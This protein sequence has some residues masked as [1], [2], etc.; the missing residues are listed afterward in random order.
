MSKTLAWVLGSLV[1]LGLSVFSASQYI[2]IDD[3]KKQ[4]LNLREESTYLEKSLNKELSTNKKKTNEITALKQELAV[5][6]ERIA[7]LEKDIKYYKGRVKKLD[8]ANKIFDKK[9]A[10]LQTEYDKLQRQIASLQNSNKIDV[11]TINTLVKEK[12]SLSDKI[13]TLNDQKDKVAVYQSKTEAELLKRQIEE[14]KIKKVNDI[15]HKTSIKFDK[16]TTQKKRFGRPIANIKSGKNWNYTIVELQ[17]DHPDK[18]VILD[19]KFMVK[20]IDSKTNQV[21]SFIESNP[22]FPDSKIDSKGIS[23][24]NNNGKIE[25]VYFNNTLKFGTDYEVRVY[26]IGDDG[27]EHRLMSGTKPFLV[28]KKLITN[29]K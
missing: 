4:V 12:E 25:I 6:Q 3:L 21:L 29:S 14:A 8:R 10:V 24:K 9:M 17:L 19:E 11:Q 27:A 28:N 5:K 22:H 2:T 1:I 16:I 7:K 13:A 23:F 26:Y 18:Q 15:V 20:V